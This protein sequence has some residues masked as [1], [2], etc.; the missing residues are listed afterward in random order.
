FPLQV[1]REV[2]LGGNPIDCSRCAVL[3]L[4]EWLGQE[5]RPKVL[6]LGEDRPLTCRYPAS[7]RGRPVVDLQGA[8]LEACRQ[9]VVAAVSVAVVAAVG[10]ALALLA[11]RFRLE[12]TYVVHVL[13]ANH[14]VGGARR[15]GRL[16][17][18]AD[19]EREF[20]AFVC[21]SKHD[22]AWV[23]G[24]L[25]PRLEGGNPRYRLCLHERD[26]PLGSLIVQNI[27]ECM[28]RS[29]RTLMVLTPSF[30][31]SQWCQWELE[32][33]MQHLL[34]GASDFLVLVELERL[35]TR[36]LPR[37]LRILLD[38]RTFLEWPAGDPGGGAAVE[39]AWQRLRAALGPPLCAS[40]PA[41]AAAATALPLQPPPP[42]TVALEAV[43]MASFVKAAVEVK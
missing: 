6:V 42:A 8:V 9:G 32:M 10:G 5:A 39:T 41:S 27:V 22:R 16:P 37:L 35:E 11:L 13:R 14:R 33:A 18:A 36:T 23:L 3:G 26:F 30:V 12:L 38:T 43:E 4:Q 24:E 25:L 17:D 2:D 1:L 28:A 21:Y 29:R 15:A 7:E 19:A 40:T 34:E 31:D 20:D